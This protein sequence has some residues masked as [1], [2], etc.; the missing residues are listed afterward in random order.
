MESRESPL[1]CFPWFADSEIDAPL[2]NED[3]LKGWTTNEEAS[4]ALRVN[5]LKRD[6]RKAA[7]F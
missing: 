7:K 3:A 5:I 6:W 1:I 2:K 4:S